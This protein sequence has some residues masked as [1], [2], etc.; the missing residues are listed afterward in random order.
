MNVAVKL[1]TLE[2]K[3]P[4][5]CASGTFGYGGELEGLV[6]FKNI[7][8][9]VGKTITL[10]PK[11][12]N[13][14][15][16][17]YETECG[18]LNSVGLENP[19][20]KGFIEEK[21]PLMSKLI[22][23]RIVSIGGFSLEEYEACLKKLEH[24]HSIDAFE[25]NL[26]CPNLRL[27]KIVSQDAMATR[28]VVK[29]LRVLTKKPL[30]IKITPEVTDISEIAK[31]VQEAGADAISLVNTFFSMSIDIETRKPRLGSIFG[32]YSGRAIKPLALYRTWQVAQHTNIPI[33][34]GGGI[35]SASD[36][37]EFFLAGATA[38]SLGTINLV[39]PNIA[40]E[41]LKDIKEYL[42]RKH[43]DDINVLRGSMLTK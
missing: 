12:G 38:V 35:A 21:L 17:I 2:L 1:G 24:E 11:V 32:G 43:V 26:S 5:I 10:E 3:T 39:Y 9:I 8:A 16:R 19:G 29:A 34:A 13:P 4:I 31:A 25:I 27:K 15:P 18:V 20:L 7:G 6:D 22:C 14:D 42:K 30:F 36:A 40:K 33:I 23:R 37:I 28:Q 41:I